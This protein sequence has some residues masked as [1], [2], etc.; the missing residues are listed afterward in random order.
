MTCPYCG[1][2]IIE[3]ADTCDACQQPL[4]FMSKPR[5]ASPIEHSL[6]KDRVRQL[7]P[8]SPLVVEVDTPVGDVLNLMVERSIGCVVVVQSGVVAGI[9]SER[10]A[11]N[12]L[13]I[14]FARHA[15]RPVAEFMTPSPETVESDARIAF[16][17]HKMDVGGYRHLPVLTNGKISGVISVRD[18]L[19]YI[20]DDLVALDS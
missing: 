1:E 20:T 4:E 19:R 15:G 6:V 9:F 11:L 8:H 7:S 17:L 18:I 5:P 13:N 2:E 10:D 3:G 12:R 16:A 14:D